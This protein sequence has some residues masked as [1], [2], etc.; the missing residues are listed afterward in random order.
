[1]SSS[2]RDKNRSTNSRKGKGFHLDAMPFSISP[3]EALDSFRTWAEE[4]QGLRYLLS[5]GSVRIGAAYVPVWSFDLNIRFDD[6]ATNTNKRKKWKPPM[7]SIYGEHQSTVYLPGLS[8]YAGY[9]YRRSLIHPVHSTS[10]VFMGDKTQPFGAWMLKDMKLQDTGAPISIAPDAWNATE[11]RSFSVVKEELQ[12]IVA[13]SWPYNKNEEPVPQVQTQVVNSRRV[14]MPTF[15]I[16]YKI[17]GLEYRAFISGCDRA[18]PIAGVSHQLWGDNNMFDHPEF[19]Q[20]SKD[21]M[22]VVAQNTP[23]V[24]Q[25]LPFLMTLI[26]PLVKGVYFL[27]LRVWAKIPIIGVAGGL[28]AGFRKIYRPYWDDRTASAEWERQRDNESIATEEDDW[29]F[30][31]ADFRDADGDAVKFFFRN[32]QRILS[33]L[34]GDED[35]AE[36]QYDWYKEWEQWAQ[37]QWQQQQRSSGSGSYQQ[38]QQQ[39]S[40]QRQ[41]Q[42]TSAS[43]KKRTE[44]HWDFD[45]NDPYSVLAIPRTAN[46]KGISQ[47]FRTQ[48]LKHH[49]DTQPNASEAQK[50]R[51]VERS[52]IITLAYRKLKSVKK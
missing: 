50:Q 42:Q 24:R 12:D 20:A 17:M 31:T 25:A 39:Q 40:Y 46:K 5:Y 34:S 8:S 35:H 52:K 38:Q 44:Y 22:S 49:P 45:E 13:S 6:K 47:G 36:G 41:Q 29:V 51:A 48:M 1:M 21:F 23:R 10:L 16:D 3:E 18:A 2:G 28:F 7:F 27:A 33:Q 9:S 26:R 11:G 32:R 4:D 19:H 43:S 15:V 14:Y 37:Q 30:Q